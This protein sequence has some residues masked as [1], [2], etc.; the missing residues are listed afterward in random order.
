MKKSFVRYHDQYDPIKTL[1][2]E[3]KGKLL[4]AIFEYNLTG[5][6]IE[7]EGMVK[8]AFMFFKGSFDRNN[9]EWKK[10]A[11]RNKENGK[12]GGRPKKNKNYD[13]GENPEEPKKPSGFIGTP[14]N[15][16]EPKKAVSGS[17]SG[18]VSVPVSGS[19]TE[20][21]QEEPLCDESHDEQPEEH[22]YMTAKKKKLTGKR[23][24]SFELFWEAFNYKKSKSSAADSWLA[25][26]ELTNHLVAQILASSKLEAQNR[27]NIID[28]GRT[29]KMAQGWLTE[30]R[31]EDEATTPT[32]AKAS[33]SFEDMMREKGHA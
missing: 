24:E 14:K 22:F 30:R 4:D 26:P 32:T 6:E 15:P 33:I 12:K 18:S 17:V 28:K 10:R 7:L 5:E 8:M 21:V 9:E 27:Q 16:H 19:G 20:V 31:W 1:S 3:D 23:L 29:P 13:L 11:D 2:L 25:I